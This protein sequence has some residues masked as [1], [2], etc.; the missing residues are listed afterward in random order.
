M[1]TSSAVT[2]TPAEKANGYIDSLT[3]LS[4]HEV[5]IQGPLIQYFKKTIKNLKL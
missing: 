5:E 4:I 1:H 3:H 2:I